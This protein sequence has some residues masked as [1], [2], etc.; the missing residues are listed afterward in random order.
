MASTI[1]TLWRNVHNFVGP[2]FYRLAGMLSSR[3][4]LTILKLAPAED[5]RLHVHRNAEFQ[6]LPPNCV[7]HWFSVKGAGPK[8]GA[9]CEVSCC[10]TQIPDSK[11]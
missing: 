3:D 1:N 5:I 7:A 9:R 11:P 8:K 6:E 10:Y 4:L 2:S